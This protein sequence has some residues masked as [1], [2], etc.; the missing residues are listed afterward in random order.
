MKINQLRLQIAL[1]LTLQLCMFQNSESYNTMKLLAL[2]T[3]SRLS[4]SH[5][6]FKIHS[7]EKQGLDGN[8]KQLAI[9]ISRF[10][11]F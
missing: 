11:L 3:P 6:L 1:I 2:T 9:V 5:L 8:V 10:S 4:S 7:E